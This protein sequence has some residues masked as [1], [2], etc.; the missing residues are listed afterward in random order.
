MKQ[1]KVGRNY[2]TRES[3]GLISWGTAAGLN[4]FLASKNTANLIKVKSSQNFIYMPSRLQADMGSF[5]GL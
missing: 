2:I 5:Q 1:D 4:R 3:S